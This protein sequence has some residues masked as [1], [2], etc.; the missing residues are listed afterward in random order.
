MHSSSRKQIYNDT[1]H[2]CQSSSSLR[3]CLG[4]WTLTANYENLGEKKKSSVHKYIR[5]QDAMLEGGTISLVFK[6]LSFLRSDISVITV[7]ISLGDWFSHSS[8]RI[9]KKWER[10]LYLPTHKLHKTVGQLIPVGQL[11]HETGRV[12]I[13]LLCLV[14][15]MLQ[16]LDTRLQHHSSKLSPLVKTPHMWSLLFHSSGWA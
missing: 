16:S 11:Q 15:R 8:V 13:P 14:T 5:N 6:M 7:I 2:P 10:S 1:Y 3:R 4:D 12:S 9:S